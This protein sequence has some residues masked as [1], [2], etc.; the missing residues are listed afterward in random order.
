M[1]HMSLKRTLFSGAALSI[2]LTAVCTLLPQA[3]AQAAPATLGT[4]QVTGGWQNVS[5][6]DP[7]VQAMAKFAVAK[8]AEGSRQELKLVS[9]AQA[10]Q[11]VVAGTN[12]RM[13]LIV[14]SRKK[15]QK[16]DVKVW[17]KLDGTQELSSWIIKR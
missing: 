3:E 9:V 12:Y 4:T 2:T 11:Q 7:Q 6:D 5:K 13:T 15:K 14:A 16:I 17:S 1:F 10:A 8:H